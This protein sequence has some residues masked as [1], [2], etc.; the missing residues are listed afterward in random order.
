MKTDVTLS[1]AAIQ[2][3]MKAEKLDSNREAIQAYL[4]AGGEGY[5]LTDKQKDLLSRWEFAD[6]MIRSN[7]GRLSRSEIAN[8]V[9]SRFKVSL[10]TAKSDL[11]SAEEVFSSSS[12]L[13]KKHRMQLRVEYLEK[14]SRLAAAAND[15]KAVA[16]IEKSIAFYLDK[17]PDLTVPQ[18]AQ[19]T[20]FIL[21]NGKDIVDDIISYED[22]EV[23]IDEAIKELPDDAE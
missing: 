18:V 4:I 5:D 3:L 15:H 1:K 22:A 20:S 6:E 11:V 14:Q 16:M 21:M 13:N 7:M 19:P 12:P 23:I 17:Y 8:L 9:V 10:C 2:P